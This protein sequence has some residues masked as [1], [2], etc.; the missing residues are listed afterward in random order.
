MDATLTD[1]YIH[2]VTRA[3]PEKQRDDVA[4]ELR[5]SIADQLDAR[6]DGGEPAAEAERDVLTA[7]GDP[8]VLAAGFADRPLHLVGPRYYLAWKRLL[9]L[10][11]WIVPVCAAVGVSLAQVLAGATIGG[12]IGTT[13]ATVIS[14][15]VH[16]C[17]WVTLVF[18]ILERSGDTESIGTWSLD[19]LPEP[20]SKGA[21]L[22]D[23]IASLIMLGALVAAVLWDHA[24]GFVWLDGGWMPLFDP[25][26]WPWGFGALAML[27]LAEAVLA[28]LVYAR[29]R[30]T[31]A[32]AVANAALALIA[33][34]VLLSLLFGPG[35]LN[36]ELVP[37]LT[38]Q[39]AEGL[40]RTVPTLIAFGIV[41]FAGWDA[42]DGFWK[43]RRR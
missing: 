42:I 15:I 1:R 25:A 6:V 2:A 38:A 26:L 39:G 32:L 23:L 9:V 3:I 12:V 4:A 10:L 14:V 13:I 20:T 5:G 33:A 8:A 40:E 19:D 18:V 30:W 36:P 28:V 11:L 31:W 37:A 35:L 21:G 43:A 22:G 27:V 24:I 16:V 41:I 17:F 7:L 34:S 29:R